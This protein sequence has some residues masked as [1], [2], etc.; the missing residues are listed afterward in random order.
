MPK[1]KTSHSSADKIFGLNHSTG[2]MKEL[3]R[4]SYFD[5]F[6][7]KKAKT[8]SFSAGSAKY[9]VVP[10]IGNVKPRNGSKDLYGSK[11]SSK[12]ESSLPE[13]SSNSSLYDPCKYLAVFY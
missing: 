10:P 5:E 6:G 8:S 1:P 13:L 12:S 9:N 3:Y 7:K 11:P 2:S 4:T